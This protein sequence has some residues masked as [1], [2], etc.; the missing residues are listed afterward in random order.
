MRLALAPLAGRSA[1]EVAVI[2]TGNY[3]ETGALDLYGPEYGLPR[4]ISGGNSLWTRGY[5]DPPPQAVIAV[6]FDLSYLRRFL[7][8]CKAVG[9]VSHRYDVKNEE[10]TWHMGLCVCRRPYDPWDGMWP[11]MQWY[12]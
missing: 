4:V 10:S 6:G 1:K 7:G 12:Q 5:G 9:V 3:G 11:K 2:L 8:A